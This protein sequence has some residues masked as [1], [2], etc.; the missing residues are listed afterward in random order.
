MLS[1]RRTP[2]ESLKQDDV[3]RP[4]RESPA[5]YVRSDSDHDT[6]QKHI[7]VAAEEDSSR[8][9][10]RD[11]ARIDSRSSSPDG[12]A[13]RPRQ[14]GSG[15]MD[16]DG[17]D[18]EP[19]NR[20]PSREQDRDRDRDRERER[21]RGRERDRYR[22]RS[23]SPVRKSGAISSDGA[24]GS[25]LD[26]EKRNNFDQDPNAKPMKVIGVFGLS[27]YTRSNDLY[28]HFGKF[29]KILKATVIIDKHTNTSRGFGF[30]DFAEL[31]DA[32][33]ARECMNG[34]VINE[35]KIRVDYSYTEKPHDGTRFDDDRRPRNDSRDED[36]RDYSDDRR[37]RD[38]DDRRSRDYH[39]DRRYDRDYDDRRRRDYDDDRRR[40]NR[41]SDD[42]RRRH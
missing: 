29:G 12:G 5:R 26:R 23:R 10:P 24:R 17:M 40:S 36:R 4:R 22:S 39:D 7:P 11:S 6:T 8:L 38:S 42:R 21:E 2:T 18:Y 32:T 9:G 28:E 13:R 15:T 16:D 19:R 25:G 1:E 27:K 14:R 31:T 34:M 41:D 20:S 30:I 35:R 37:R 33:R 3:T